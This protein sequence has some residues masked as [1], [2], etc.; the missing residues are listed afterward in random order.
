MFN[1]AKLATLPN[2]LDEINIT[3][4]LDNKLTEQMETI[5]P[6]YNIPSTSKPYDVGGF[7]SLQPPANATLSHFL[8]DKTENPEAD[9]V[10]SRL[11]FM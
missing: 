10:C 4:M 9:T 3:L 8:E 6:Y 1:R 7:L 11:N 2:I 5:A